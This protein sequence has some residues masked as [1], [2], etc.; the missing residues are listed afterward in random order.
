[1]KLQHI[2]VPTDFSER[3]ETAIKVAGSLVDFFGCTVDLIHSVPVMKYFHES[4]DPLGVP[5][6]L[7]K[8]LYPHSLD[9]AQERLEELAEK[10]IKKEYR[11]KMV[12]VVERKASEAIYNQANEGKY[13]MIL[14]SSKGE[15]NSIHVMG[16]TTEQVIR[17]SHVPV[18]TI[19]DHLD[20]DGVKTILVPI[21]F[22]EYSF[23]SVIPAFELANELGA[24]IVLLNI[25]ELY[26]AGTDMIPYVPTT[27][28]EQP[29]YESIITKL[30]EYLLK[31]EQYNLFIQRS[32][33]VFEDLL[34]NS[35]GEHTHTVE[36]ETRII[37]GI[38]AH[39]EIADFANE[40]ADL[41]VM[42]T[43]GRTGLARV[44]IGSTTE[45]VS[46][47][48]EVPMLTVRP[49]FYE[50]EVGKPRAEEAVN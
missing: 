38:S 32:G 47:Q 20:L 33:V 3:A 26:S 1:M 25:V 5:F 44:F 35:E 30:S 18:L 28:D 46:R 29:V 19:D 16:G 27:I 2:L 12:S 6:S 40:N 36:V 39:H 24:K 14:M 8:H 22:S 49:E 21:D 23:F 41:V 4:M 17:H 13:D 7:E 15:H 11:G 42:S 45:Q 10:Y 48:L 31:N 34:I 43:H 50:E 37:K 9:R